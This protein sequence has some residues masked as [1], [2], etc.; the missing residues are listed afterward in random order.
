MHYSASYT[1]AV[2]ELAISSNRTNNVLNKLI[3]SIE[4]SFSAVA[5]DLEASRK[6]LRDVHADLRDEIVSKTNGLHKG[7]DYRSDE[8]RIIEARL[9][10]IEKQI[11][12]ER[13]TTT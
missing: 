2:E 4:V 8:N 1:K 6:A 7:L 13:M 3:A 10:R 12:I 9:D 11:G 5:D